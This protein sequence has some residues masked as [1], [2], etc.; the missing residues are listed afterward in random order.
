[1]NSKSGKAKLG[2][3]LTRVAQVAILLASLLQVQAAQVVSATQEVVSLPKGAITR[4]ASPNGKW[5]LVFECPN[6]CAERKLWIED[7]SSRA[8]RLVKE[9]DRDLDISWAPDGR[10]F[11]VNDNSGSNGALCYVYNPVDLKETDLTAAVTS[12]DAAAKKFLEAGH[13]YLNA[14]RWISS[15]ELLVALWGHF[16]DPPARGFTILYRVNLAGGIQKLSQRN[17]EQ[18]Q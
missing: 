17:E 16:D 4:L 1:M 6:D 9:Y 8:R 14:K 2:P 5:T 13:A 3:M 12:G 15:R 7:S 11:F 18:P 10:S